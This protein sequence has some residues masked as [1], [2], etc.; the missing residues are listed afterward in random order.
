MAATR[1][2]TVTWTGSLAEGSGTVSAGS[3]ELFT[4]LP[5]SWAA[6]TEA[7]QGQTS[8]EELL[9]A[10]HASCFS[11]AL[12]AGLGRAGTPPEHLH[13][14]ATVTFDK[15]GDAWT[16]TASQIDVVGV[17]HGIDDSG[18][19]AAARDAGQ[20]CPI[21]RALAGNVEVSVSAAL[22]DPHD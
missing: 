16:V 9:A 7:P 20:N 12:S 18:F 4:D 8:P 13:V 15:V 17:V 2:S 21:S 10:A 6:R 3:S 19:D 22:E 14:S 11:M 1:T 5:V